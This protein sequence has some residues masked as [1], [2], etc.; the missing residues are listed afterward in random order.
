M[1]YPRGLLDQNNSI[2][3]IFYQV[4]V[5]HIAYFNK[6][7]KW[8][9]GIFVPRSDN[10]VLFLLTDS[11]K[12]E[13]RLRLVKKFER[14]PLT[15]QH[16]AQST[17]ES[18]QYNLWQDRSRHTGS[19]NMTQFCIGLHLHLGGSRDIFYIA[20]YWIAAGKVSVVDHMSIILVGL[21]FLLCTC[22]VKRPFYAGA[23]HGIYG[24]PPFR[25]IPL[26][27]MFK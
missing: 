7:H 21:I 24:F 20:I 11:L 8:K 10:L 12:K 4:L 23:S 1:Y 25:S 16:A 17:G 26:P 27:A 6:S 5:Q 15:I 2:Q 14:E 18:F 19:L 9:Y 3:E 13:L 22:H